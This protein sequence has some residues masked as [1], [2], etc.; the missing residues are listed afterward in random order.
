MRRKKA[1]ERDIAKLLRLGFG[2]GEG[3]DYKPWQTV[4]DFSSR[5]NSHRMYSPKT[6]RTHHL[7]SNIERAL[8]LKAEFGATFLEY[9]EQRAMNREN[10]LAIAKLLGVKHPVFVGTDVPF[11]MTLDA[12]VLRRTPGSGI[13]RTGY[14]VKEVSALEDRRTLEKLSISKMYCEQLG[15][16]HQIVTNQTIPRNTIKNLEWIRCGAPKDGE[17]APVHGFFD[18]HPQRMLLRLLGTRPEQSVSDFCSD[19]DRVDGLQPG[20]GLR[21]IQNLLWTHQLEADLDGEPIHLQQV[22][23]LLPARAAHALAKSA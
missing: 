21:I 23:N 11:V 3:A 10:T 1:E 4:H 13:S 20:T 2:S 14:D 5:G 18:Q 9:Q 12:V 17:V 8:F 6:G 7:F 15:W 16:G 19:Y 22:V